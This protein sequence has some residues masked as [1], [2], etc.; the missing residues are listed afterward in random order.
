MVSLGGGEEIALG[1]FPFLIGK[2]EG[3]VDYALKKE[4][5]SRLH[6]R[7]DRTEDGYEVTDLNSTNGVRVGK[8]ILQANETAEIKPGDELYLAEYGFLFL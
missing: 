1:Y 8:K 7:I 4:T 6:V 2:Q 5:V 3:L